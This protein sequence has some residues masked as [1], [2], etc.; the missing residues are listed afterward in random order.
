MFDV[1][2]I[3]VC[4]RFV[5]I[6]R[7]VLTIV[8][9]IFYFR[10][11]NVFPKIV[12]FKMHSSSTSIDVHLFAGNTIFFIICCHNTITYSQIPICV[13]YCLFFCTVTRFSCFISQI[14]IY[15]LVLNARMLC[16]VLYER[17][18]FRLFIQFVQ[19][20]VWLI[21]VCCARDKYLEKPP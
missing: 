1:R 13:N 11:E 21:V 12:H 2:A 3:A 9:T 7:I 6:N 5:W 14:S 16:T 4:V 10:S 15:L 19:L 18:C 20:S 17:C 8:W